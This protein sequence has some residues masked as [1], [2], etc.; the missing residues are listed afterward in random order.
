M[1]MLARHAV[2]ARFF[3]T[4]ADAE[5]TPPLYRDYH[6][7]KLNSLRRLPKRLC[8]D[9]VHRLTGLKAT[10]AQLVGDLTTSARESRKWNLS[11]GLYSQ[12]AEDFPPIFLD[13]ATTVFVLGA[14]TESGLAALAKTFGFNES[15]THS[16]GRFS[17]PGPKGSSIAALF[18]TQS[19]RAQDVLTLALSPE[20]RWAFSTTAEDAAIRDELY[21]RHGVDRTLGYL[22]RRWPQGLKSVLEERIALIEGSP[23]ADAI[24]RLIEEASGALATKI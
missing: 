22:A 24:R 4:P 5:L 9:E 7:A 21:G 17:P 3:L 20:L 1:Y 18:K 6:R 23:R 2:G 8:Y 14:G 11:I 16:L 19:G 15:V 13:L 12:T 10:S